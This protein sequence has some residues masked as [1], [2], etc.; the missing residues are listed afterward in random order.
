VKIDEEIEVYSR[1]GV[2]GEV[3]F[4]VERFVFHCALY[5]TKYVLSV[6]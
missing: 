5:P 3:G 2:N 1:S 6:K 4:V